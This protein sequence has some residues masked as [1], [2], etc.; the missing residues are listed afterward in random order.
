MIPLRPTSSPALVP[1]PEAA[2]IVYPSQDGE[3]LAESDVHLV[4]I[5]TIFSILKQ[6]LATESSRFSRSPDRPGTVLSDQFFYYAQ[7]YPRLRVAPDIMV[8]FDVLPGGRDHYKLWDEGEVPAIIFEVTSKGTQ[9]EDQTFKK[10]LY[11]QLGVREYWQ[12]DPKGEWIAEQL[13]GYRHDGERYRLIGDRRSELLQLRLVVEGTCLAFYREDTGQK[14]LTPD[15]L[16]EVNQELT[17]SNQILMA[18]QAAAAAENDRLR[19]KLREL[20]VELEDLA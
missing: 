18:A 9:D 16:A 4:A 8:I 3:P 20:G 5:V 11:E 15:E 19:A 10:L 2:E 6:Y 1:V 13:V 7:G 17:E 14:L 12:F